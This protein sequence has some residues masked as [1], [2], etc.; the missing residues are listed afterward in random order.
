[1]TSI[2]IATQ[3]LA[4][5]EA[6][7]IPSALGAASR[8]LARATGGEAALALLRD[9]V[10]VLEPAA[11]PLGLARALIDLGAAL[12]RG[13]HRRAAREPL[14]RGLELAHSHDARPLVSAAR[15]ELH[16]VGARPRRAIRSGVPALTPSQRRV[17]ELAAGG[18]SN[19]EIA[20]RLFISVKTVEHHLT[21]VYRTL[22]VHS[23][24]QLPA[25]LSAEHP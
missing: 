16:A 8:V 18:L 20:A 12:R 17:A 3:D 21:A 10:A 1:M 23:R 9:A 14:E 19:A 4:I 25:A 7:D 24:T 11:V 2:A 15:T 22:D 6:A 13:G 5:A